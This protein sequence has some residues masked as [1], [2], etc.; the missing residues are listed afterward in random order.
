MSTFGL[1]YGTKE[2]YAFRLDIFTQKDVEYIKI[3]ADQ[4]NTFTV[5]HNQFSTWTSDEYKRILGYKGPQELGATEQVEILEDS[6]LSASVDWRTKGAVN[7]VKNQGHCGS[8]WAF[9]ATAAIEGHHFIHS[10]HLISLAE[11]EFV[12]CDTKSHGCNGGL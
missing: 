7:P 2:E 12:D 8:C 6:N 1:S 11:Q 10:G 9:S 3:N 5:G 4:E